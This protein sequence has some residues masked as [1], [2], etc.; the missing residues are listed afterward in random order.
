MRKLLTLAL[1]LLLFI[2]C[3]APDAQLT[4]EEGEKTGSE[5]PSATPLT[6]AEN[7]PIEGMPSVDF[8]KHLTP[9]VYEKIIQASTELDVNVELIDPASGVQYATSS[10]KDKIDIIALDGG[11]RRVL[12]SIDI[13]FSWVDLKA[14]VGQELFVLMKNPGTDE[15][16]LFTLNVDS[17]VEH[18][19]VKDHIYNGPLTSPFIVHEQDVYFIHDPER[20]QVELA[21]YN[22]PTQVLSTVAANAF[23]IKE[24]KGELYYMKMADGQVSLVKSKFDGVEHEVIKPGLLIYDYYFLEDKLDVLTY[25]NYGDEWHYFRIEDYLNKGPMKQFIFI[26]PNIYGSDIV[27]ATA[28]HQSIVIYEDK[29]IALPVHEAV[30]RDTY[31]TLEHDGMF[32]Y[33]TVGDEETH[34]YKIEKQKFIDLI[35]R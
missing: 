7:T 29:I 30:D 11:Q 13:A 27:L 4:T 20:D 16:R 18:D 2:S 24:H 31:F 6:P 25:V 17:L 28:E 10:S 22:V 12:K 19:I 15:G 23:D 32:Y 26:Q 1:V 3:S 14:I 34:F 8:A 9:E 21:K 35:M 33:T 5:A